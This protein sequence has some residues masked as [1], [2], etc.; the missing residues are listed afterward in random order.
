MEGVNIASITAIAYDRHI[1][2]ITYNAYCAH[3]YNISSNSD[4]EFASALNLRASLKT[5]HPVNYF[6]I[7]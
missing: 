4:S 5:I 3:V 1:N 7:Q 6:L 2:N